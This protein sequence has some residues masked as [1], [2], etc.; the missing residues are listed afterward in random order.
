MTICE[1]HLTDSKTPSGIPLSYG[2]PAPGTA[3]LIGPAGGT[4]AIVDPSSPIHGTILTVPPGALTAPVRIVMREGK[5]SGTFG[6]GPSI[7][8]LPHGLSFRIPVVLTIAR[9]LLYPESESMNGHLEPAFYKYDETTL[10]WVPC[11]RARP[12]DRDTTL[13]C[14]LLQF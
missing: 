2:A 7:E 6:M 9:R 14:E 1:H 10:D 13:S 12:A 11:Q 8:L 5:H 3:A 4:L